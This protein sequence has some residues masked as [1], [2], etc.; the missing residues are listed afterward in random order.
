MAS[1]VAS[2]SC[3]ES[4]GILSSSVI[5][6]METRCLFLSERY[7]PLHAQ[8][9]AMSI[10]ASDLDNYLARIFT[11]PST[12]SK[13]FCNSRSTFSTAS[14]TFTSRLLEL[15]IV[16]LISVFLP[17]KSARRSHGSPSFHRT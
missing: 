17:Q 1:S 2:E 9:Q 5:P 13:P 3:M 11:R 12:N 14:V 15:K 7:I 4:L 16:L 6:V 10:S 8:R